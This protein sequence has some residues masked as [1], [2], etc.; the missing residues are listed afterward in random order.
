V[1][2]AFARIY[3][4]THYPLDVIAGALIGTAFALA[5]R[6]PF[7]RRRLEKL[8]QLLSNLWD[9]ATGLALRRG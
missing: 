9:Q 8:A 6:V 2:V 5:L 3:V 7:I 1:P 4:G